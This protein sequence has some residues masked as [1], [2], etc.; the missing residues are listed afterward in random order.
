MIATSALFGFLGDEKRRAKNLFIKVI[1]RLTIKSAKE[2]Y[3][4]NTTV[5]I[6]CTRPFSAFRSVATT[7]ATL[8]FSSVRITFPSFYE[9]AKEI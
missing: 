4:G 3:L 6:T 8:P 7:V 1:A 5:S 9:A 2:N